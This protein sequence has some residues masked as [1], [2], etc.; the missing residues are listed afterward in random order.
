MEEQLAKAAKEAR[1]KK[2]LLD[3]YGQT[4]ILGKLDPSSLPPFTTAPQTLIKEEGAGGRGKHSKDPGHGK[5][6]E[7]KKK[8]F[9]RVAGSRGVDEASFQPNLSLAST[10]TGMEAI[11][12]LNPGVSI[13]SKI[14]ERSG[15]PVPEDA[16]RISKKTY[17]AKTTPIQPSISQIDDYESNGTE[18]YRRNGSNDPKGTAKKKTIRFDGSV[19][20]LDVLPDI[21][22]LEGSRKIVRENNAY[23]L[24]DDDLGLGPINSKGLS[25]A[26]VL[27]KKPNDKQ[28]LGVELL[29]QSPDGGK[30][31]DRDLVKNMKPVAE[32]KHLAAPPLGHVGGHGLVTGESPH[33]SVIMSGSLDSGSYSSEWFQRRKN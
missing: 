20:S 30:P 19:K 25:P 24:S 4:V 6:A 27:P 1:G 31:K 33:N 26:M 12:K 14:G 22:P 28:R 21:D 29:V 3:R 9:V 10:L 2:F 8:R 32:R 11:P 7:G 16:R 13:K 15:D 18:G 17:L 23:D 5:D